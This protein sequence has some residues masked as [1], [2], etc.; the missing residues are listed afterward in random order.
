ML[1]PDYGARYVKK[2]KHWSEDGHLLQKNVETPR[3]LY[4]KFFK[5]VGHAENNFRA[6]ELIMEL[7]V[8]AYRM[9][10]EE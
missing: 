9:Q 2:G 4:C 3:N 8:D 1:D 6:Y 10:V 7:G 5:L